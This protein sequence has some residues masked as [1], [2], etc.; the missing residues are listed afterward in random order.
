M[1]EI[2]AST[3]RREGSSINDIFEAMNA[4]MPVIC[5]CLDVSHVHVCKFGYYFV[6]EQ[7]EEIAVKLKYLEEEGFVFSTVNSHFKL[8]D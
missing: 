5:L 4:S 8:V 7:K 6:H 3:A 1:R 2:E